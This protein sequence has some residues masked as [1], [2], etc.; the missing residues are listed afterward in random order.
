LYP[1]PQAR[2]TLLQNVLDALDEAVRL[3]DE[4]LSDQVDI[5]DII[6]IA[7]PGQPLIPSAQ[8]GVEPW[9]GFNKR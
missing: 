8:K 1:D 3:E 2:Q 9:T 5:M 7:A 6:P 4:R